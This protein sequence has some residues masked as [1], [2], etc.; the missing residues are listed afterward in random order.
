MQLYQ[1]L[2]RE[3]TFDELKF[4]FSDDAGQGGVLLSLLLR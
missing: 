4:A 3:N 1:N 2:R